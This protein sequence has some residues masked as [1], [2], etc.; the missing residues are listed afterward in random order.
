MIKWHPPDTRSPGTFCVSVP[1][2][3]AGAVFHERVEDLL[4]DQWS[5]ARPRFAE[6]HRPQVIAELTSAFGYSGLEPVEHV[7]A[8]VSLRALPQFGPLDLEFLGCWI[9]HATQHASWTA[10]RV[11]IPVVRGSIA[12]HG[13]GAEKHLEWEPETAVLLHRIPAPALSLLPA[14]AV[15]IRHRYTGTSDDA[16]GRRTHHLLGA[17]YYS[18][19]PPP[20][21]DQQP[22]EDWWRLNLKH[23]AEEVHVNDCRLDRQ[24]ASTANPATSIYLLDSTIYL[25]RADDHYRLP[26]TGQRADLLEE[27]RE[28][29]GRSTQAFAHVGV[30]AEAAEILAGSGIT[31]R[32]V[33]GLAEVMSAATG[34][35]ARALAGRTQEQWAAA[36]WSWGLKYVHQPYAG[37]TDLDLCW[38][39]EDAASLADAGIGA[40]RAYE[41]RGLGHR[42]LA[43]V[44][45]ADGTEPTP[46]ARSALAMLADSDDPG[47]ADLAARLATAR[48]ED[49]DEVLDS[50]R[51]EVYGL[52]GGRSGN[53][54]T[55]SRT[56]FA[57]ADGSDAELFTVANEWWDVGEDADA[58]G[59]STHYTT[60][61][62]A[63]AEYARQS[64]ELQEPPQATKPPEWP[65][66]GPEEPHCDN[67]GRPEPYN[68]FIP[69][70]GWMYAN[71]GRACG[72][73]CYDA[74]SD[75][76][77]EHAARFHQ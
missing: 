5:G 18:A 49:E 76:P 26:L 4:L 66:P 1:Q 77:G 55:L 35:D 46:A 65:C 67:C 56:R 42:D 30:D 62:P 17:P 16:L 13:D 37:P 47:D 22:V 19:C 44:I 73:D 20:P 40:A 58:G 2:G 43:A 52:G 6:E 59:E 3:T 60:E 50:S 33:L 14:D 15:V 10:P 34:A 38:P 74:M 11:E 54:V 72:P 31:P 75:A 51:D 12:L 69:Q 32:T 53:Q 63:R 24:A 39:A 29:Y 64:A 71:L 68:E 61:A 48:T 41:L 45:A 70:L 28:R 27:L 25:D 36:G 7:D 9:A 57:L 21:R 8:E 23:T